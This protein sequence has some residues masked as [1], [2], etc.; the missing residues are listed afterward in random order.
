MRKRGCAEEAS[1]WTRD[2]D[3][4]GAPGSGHPPL[5]FGK[6]HLQPGFFWHRRNPSWR[7][8]CRLKYVAVKHSRGFVL[9]PWKIRAVF[10]KHERKG[11]NMSSFD[12]GEI[13]I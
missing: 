9:Q 13:F 11:L 5:D 1:G 4:D 8:A 10:C 12:L 6:P 7:S 2:N 3:G